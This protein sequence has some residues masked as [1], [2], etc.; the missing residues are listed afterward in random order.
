M[1]LS[2]HQAPYRGDSDDWLTPPD[3]LAALGPFDLDPCASQAQ[4]WPTAAAHYT[5]L[6]D[7]LAQE[8]RGLVWLN[9]P[10]GP[11]AATWLDRLAGYGTGIALVPARTETRW[12]VRHVWGRADAVLFLTPRPHFYRPDGTRA[13]ANSG[14][15]ICLVAYGEEAAARLDK[16]GLP[17]T[18]VETW[19]IRRTA[20]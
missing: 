8:W 3:I 11:E 13:A 18:L 2:S 10:F 6:D 12:F 16:S 17:G 4:P 15:P 5:I 20:S 7:G 9:P 14:A 19:T 1:S